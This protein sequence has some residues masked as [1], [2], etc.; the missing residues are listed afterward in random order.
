MNRVARALAPEI[1]NE[2][3]DVGVWLLGILVHTQEEVTR[4]EN[5]ENVFVDGD[6]GAGPRSQLLGE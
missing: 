4:T 1:G 3:V 2:K 6:V 5:L